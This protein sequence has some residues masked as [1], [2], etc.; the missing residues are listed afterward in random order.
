MVQTA[1]EEKDEQKQLGSHQR[2]KEQRPQ[3]KSWRIAELAGEGLRG[4]GKPKETIIQC[5]RISRH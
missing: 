3:N 4:A 5:P 1:S 2:H